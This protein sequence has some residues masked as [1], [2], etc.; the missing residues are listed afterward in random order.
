MGV[1]LAPSVVDRESAH[2]LTG[3]LV[4]ESMCDINLL[5]EQVMHNTICVDDDSLLQ[6]ESLV[7]VSSCRI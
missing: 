5:Y 3:S 6:N 2:E 7:S 4:E 1:S